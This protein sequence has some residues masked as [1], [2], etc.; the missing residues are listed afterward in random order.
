MTRLLFFCLLGLAAAGVAGEAAKPDAPT[1]P[2]P[3]V[4]LEVW[5]EKTLYDG[6]T[7]KFA[8]SGNVVVIRADL[9]VDCETMDGVMDPK[10]R[11]LSAVTAVGD[12]RMVTIGAWTPMKDG[13][14]PEVGKLPPDGWR[15]RSATAHY[16]LKAGHL[17]LSGK[18][19]EGRP[20]LSRDRGYGEADKIIFL[21]DKGEYE[22][23]GDPVLIGDL[24]TGP[25]RATPPTTGGAK[26]ATKAGG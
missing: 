21:P 10:T 25:V 13:S 15:A 5:A 11:Q 7:G 3:M 22:L 23:E 6:A 2:E 4:P 18:T 17:V 24:P 1:Q 26:P 8:F 16:D 19:K 20:R 12:V 9:R 14:P